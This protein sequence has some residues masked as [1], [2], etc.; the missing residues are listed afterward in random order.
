[1]RQMRVLGVQMTGS[2][3]SPQELPV[4]R[5]NLELRV[6]YKLDEKSDKLVFRILH[7]PSLGRRVCSDMEQ[8]LQDLSTALPDHNFFRSLRNQAEL[9]DLAGMP[10]I[11]RVLAKLGEDIERLDSADAGTAGQRQEELQRQA[12]EAQAMIRGHISSHGALHFRTIAQDI[13]Q[14]I[15]AAIINARQ[16]VVLCSPS[17][18]YD[19]LQKLQHPLEKA[20]ERGIRVFLLWGLK[21]TDALADSVANRLAALKAQHGN[22]LVYT[23]DPARIGASFLVKDC[24]LVIAS[25]HPFLRAAAGSFRELAICAESSTPEQSLDVAVELLRYSRAAYPNS[26]ISA[27]LR[28]EPEEFRELEYKN[29]EPKLP[30]IPEP[31]ATRSGNAPYNPVA[32]TLWRRAWSR[33]R[34]SLDRLV[35]DAGETCL[36]I[37]DARHRDILWDLLKRPGGR[38]IILSRRLERSVVN[39]AMLSQLNLRLSTGTR[40]LIGFSRAEPEALRE[41]EGLERAYPDKLQ[42]LNLEK[43]G[44]VQ[45][46]NVEAVIGDE[47]AVV[48]SF[49]FLS[50]SGYYDKKRRTRSEVGLVLQGGAVTNRLLRDLRRRYSEIGTLVEQTT[51]S[52]PAAPALPDPASAD[53]T[54]AAETLAEP[55]LQALLRRLERDKEGQPLSSRTRAG[56]LRRY[57]EALPP[58][59][60]AGLALRML[61]SAHVPDA[62]LVAACCLASRPWDEPGVLRGFETLIRF[63]WHEHADPYT[64]TIF[65]PL[66]SSPSE[67]LPPL[68]LAELWAAKRQPELLRD[69]L[70][71]AALGELGPHTSSFACIALSALFLHGTREAADSIEMYHARFPA[72]LASWAEVGLEY[73]RSTLGQALPVDRVRVLFERKQL[74]ADAQLLRNQLQSSFEVARATSFRFPLGQHT[75]DYLFSVNGAM[76]K[77]E[78]MIETSNFKQTRTWLK[79]HGDA[80]KLLDNATDAIWHGDYREN[81]IHYPKRA[82]LLSR[83][84][85]VLDKTHDW[86]KRCEMQSEADA[87]EPFSAELIR[88]GQR[89]QDRRKEVLA[90]YEEARQD[91]RPEAPLLAELLSELRPILE[92]IK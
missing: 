38:L 8:A 29:T 58:G 35:K 20:M 61:E 64:A 39:G 59:E 10:D 49:P 1:M 32:L 73:H 4:E 27:E 3:N 65:L 62:P 17:I 41:L 18:Q 33:Y 91:F 89:L 42:L 23:S 76:G 56:E 2:L 69:R 6:D 16:Q 87:A 74:Q 88:V 19:V 86:V 68:W 13:Q 46:G 57:F 15:V 92:V 45:T 14:E 53:T 75:W 21:D 12:A 34:E 26:L 72:P 7:P 36:M 55:G 52:E 78:S 83:L 63:D 81:R 70:L 37:R 79:T 90:L 40:M 51:V 67:D 60:A 48:S 43:A 24:D 84:R 22:R 82:P 85:N 44:L 50:E 47:L 54:A 71:N 80:D 31:P 66:C 11:S 5:V 77:L 9:G 28:T 30:M 25:S